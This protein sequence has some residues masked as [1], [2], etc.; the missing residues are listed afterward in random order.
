MLRIGEAAKKFD[1]SN[2]TLRYWEEEGILNSTRTEK[3]YRFYDDENT[4]RIK[5]IVMLRK[6]RMPIA[7]IER[8]FISDDFDAAIDALTSHL[9]NLR[10][11]AA[12]VNSLSTLIEKLI[13]HIKAEKNLA[14]VFSYLEKQSRTTDSE[15]EK[16]LQTILS[17]RK[18]NM[19]TNL[20]SDVRIVRLPAMTVASYQAQSETPEKDCSEV[21]NKFVLENSLHRKSGFRHFGFN[22][23]SPSENNPVYGYE[24]WVAIPENFEVHE[25]LVKK[26]FGGGLYAS[27]STK[28][29]EIGDRWQQLYNW[30]KNN[31]KYDVDFS[32]QWLEECTDFET[33][34]S[35]DESAQQLD[36]LEPISLNKKSTGI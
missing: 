5:Q 2:R 4:T 20:L 14:Q 30:A 12:V 34:I 3:G 27:I 1:I 18:N 35:G 8:I 16:A 21:M 36:L 32:F 15:L 13:R 31:D 23:P 9:E 25:P 17:E 26:Q 11:E 7:D 24:M 10:Q 28:M 29:G 33:F 6:L 22:N 19:S